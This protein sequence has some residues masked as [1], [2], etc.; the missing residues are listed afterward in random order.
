MEE[1]EAEGK[2]DWKGS[3]RKR[4]KDSVPHSSGAVGGRA[5]NWVIAWLKTSH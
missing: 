5:P 4:R 1:K 3:G 2:K